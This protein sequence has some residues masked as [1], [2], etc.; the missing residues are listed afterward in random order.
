MT[1][2]ASGW[3]EDPRDTN[4]L[5]YFDGV[6]WTDHVRPRSIPTASTP[7]MPPAPGADT[8]AWPPQYGY[9]ARG[10]QGV[11]QVTPPGQ[12]P[13]AYGQQGQYGQQ[14]GQ[15][16]QQPWN[17]QPW[18]TGPFGAAGVAQGKGMTQDGDVYSGWWRRVGASLLDGLIVGVV[19]SA[20]TF[21][22][23][24]SQINEITAWFEAVMDAAAEG[25][26]NAVDSVAMPTQA[27][28]VIGLFNVVL[29]FLYE[30][31]QLK[32]FGRTIGKRAVDISV[33]PAAQRGPLSWGQVLLRM[34]VK[35]GPGVLGNVVSFLSTFT[36][37]FA[38]LDVLWPLWDPRKQALHDKAAGT[39]VVRGSGSW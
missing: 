24:G 18:A 2:P 4:Q 35:S 15:Y 7:A 23:F 16:T 29:T 34:L 28:L 14:Q 1:Q 27:L 20:L 8:P 10:G 11:Q 6:V 17:S 32:W 22:L 26:T 9:D 25:D 30:A 31:L 21:L 12:Q 39:V 5:R 37:L 3:Y 33:R 38:L 19:S 36:A 13:P